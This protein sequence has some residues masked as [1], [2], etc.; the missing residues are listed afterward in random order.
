MRLWIDDVRSA[1]EWATHTARTPAEAVSY[2]EEALNTG[3]PIEHIAFDHDLG[4]DM[5]VVLDVRAVVRWLEWYDV[6]PESA[7][8]HTS[9]PV[10]RK[11]LESALKG[12]TKIVDVYPE[13]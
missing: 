8:I 11:W 4:A 2:L 7:S 6:Y 9:N 3:E 12:H 10:G 5:G 1:P 13:L